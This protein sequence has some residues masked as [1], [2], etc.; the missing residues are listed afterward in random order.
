MWKLKHI[1][2]I[3]LSFAEERKRCYVA[4]SVQTDKS[5]C[6]VSGVSIVVEFGSWAKSFL[7]HSFS[8]ISLCVCTAIRIGRSG[9]VKLILDPA[10]DQFLSLKIIKNFSSNYKKL[11]N[12]DI[13]NIIYSYLISIQWN[14]TVLVREYH[15]LRK[16][17]FSWF[18]VH[19]NIQFSI[20]YSFILIFISPLAQML[21]L[22][23]TAWNVI[24]VTESQI[25]VFKG[26]HQ[27]RVL[28]TLM[29]FQRDSSRNREH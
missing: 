21:A 2:S 26:L 22:W 27:E 7:L 19:F 4:G 15:S 18:A 5:S 8:F 17:T 3:F 11:I 10:E 1:F 20:L 6:T 9:R 25:P 28:L 23:P 29:Y 14:V 12:H 16:K 24:H 13:T